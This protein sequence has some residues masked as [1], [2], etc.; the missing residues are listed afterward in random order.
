VSNAEQ[1]NEPP[2]IGDAQGPFVKVS[3]TTWVHA[4]HVVTVTSM[5]SGPGSY[6][7]LDVADEDTSSPLQVVSAATPE[8]IVIDLANALSDWEQSV[9]EYRERGRLGV[10]SEDESEGPS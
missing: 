4:G 2:Q 10:L 8:V 6:V 3:A 5:P 1:N 7:L 9:G